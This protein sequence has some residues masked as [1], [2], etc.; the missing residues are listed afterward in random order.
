MEYAV[1]ADGMG[2]SGIVQKLSANPWMLVAVTAVLIVIYILL[3]GRKT[4]AIPGLSSNP[5][6][7]D[8]AE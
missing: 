4:R 1:A 5:S 6:Y 2:L 8:T 7:T 3:F